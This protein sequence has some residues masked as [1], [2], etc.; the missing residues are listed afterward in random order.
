MRRS[1]HRNNF[2][3]HQHRFPG[4]TADEIQARIKR[5]GELLGRFSDVRVERRSK[6]IFSIN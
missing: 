3:Y 5:L 2:A 4:V 1:G 6:Y